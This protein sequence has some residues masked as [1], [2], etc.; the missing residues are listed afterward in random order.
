MHGPSKHL[1]LRLIRSE[2]MLHQLA[3]IGMVWA[4]MSGKE[5]RDHGNLGHPRH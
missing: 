4:A 3:M 2:P 1:P 5:G